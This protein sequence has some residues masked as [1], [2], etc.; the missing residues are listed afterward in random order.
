MIRVTNTMLVNDL[1]RNLNTNM[2]LMEK[3]HRQLETGRK[4]NKP[5]DNPAGLVKSL[6]LRTNLTEGE[7]Y[8][9]NISEA[10]N[11]METTDSAFNN[12]GSILHRIRVLTVNAS[13]VGVNDTGALTAIADEIGELNDQLKMI[14]NTTYGSKHVFAGTNI[15]EQPYTEGT[16]PNNHGWT[17]N[18]NYL[19]LEI[20][21]GVKMPIN[22]T[23]ADMNGFFTSEIKFGVDEVSGDDIMYAGGIFALVERIEKNIRDVADG[24]TDIDIDANLTVLDG[25]M[26]DLLSARSA[27]GAKINRLDLQLNRLEETQISYTGLLSKN[28]DADQA[29][30][31]MY[32]KVQETVYRASLAAG[33]RIIQPTLIDFIR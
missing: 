10:I 20:A 6:R 2:R 31:I 24:A 4:I 8:I 19:E 25:K 29:E 33:A 21:I 9:N 26:E 27:I 32:L 13:N 1:T 15:T 11:F 16:T 28:E 23:D 3:Y 18:D 22:L 17:A 14:A 5:S 7:Q 30:V 12:I